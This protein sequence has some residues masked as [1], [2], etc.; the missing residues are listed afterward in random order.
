MKNLYFLLF[1]ISFSLQP[2]TAQNSTE[3]LLEN[4]KD[5]HSIPR[6][7]AYLHLN[8][9]VLLQGEQ[10]GFSAYIINKTDLKPSKETT[11]LYVQVKKEGGEIVREK[12]L[13]VEEGVASNL[14]EIDENFPTGSYTITAFTNWMRNFQEQ[15]FFTENFRVIETDLDHKAGEVVEEIIDVQFLPESGHLL[16]NVVNSIGII[17]KD[18]AGNGVA[19]A[20]VV[21]RD[22]ENRDLAN[23]RLNKFGIGKF[24]MIPDPEENYTAV[25]VKEE[26]EIPV[27][28]DTPIEQEGIILTTTQRGDELR[29]LVS[30]NAESL[31]KIERRPLTLTIQNR[32]LVDAHEIEFREQKTIPVIVDLSTLASGINI[33]TLFDENL[34]PI[35]ERL[36]FNHHDLPVM[37]M[38]TAQITSLQDSLQFK[39]PMPGTEKVNF[40][41]SILPKNTISANRHHNIIS[42]NLLQ[43]YVRG[44]IENAGWYFEENSQDRRFELDNLL[45][46]QG[47][48]SYDWDEIFNSELKFKHRF[49]KNFE[50]KAT[51]HSRDVD[52]RE[53][54]YLVHATANNN[55]L[56]AEIPSEKEAFIF[57]GFR[58]VEGEQIFI[59][60][61]KRN[62]KLVPA[63]LALQSFPQK[64]P[65]FHLEAD[66]LDQK[67]QKVTRS[68]NG[69]MQVF[70]FGENI[71]ELGEVL[72][73]TKLDKVK[74]R[75]R[76]LNNHI[77]GRAHV[78]E[79]DDIAM[80]GT[81]ANLLRSKGLRVSEAN[82]SFSVATAISGMSNSGAGG[83]TLEGEMGDI[84]GERE[85][86]DKTG[87]GSGVAVY[88]DGILLYDLTQLYQYPLAYVDYVEINNTGMGNGF[89]G[90]KGHIKI[91]T[92]RGSRYESRDRNR[93][94]EFDLPLAYSLE[95]EFYVPRY[96]STTDDFFQAYG[97]ID[98]KVG[99]ASENGEDVN[100]KIDKPKVDYQ[101]IIEGFT[102]AGNFVYDVQNFSVEQ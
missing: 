87:L 29:L 22:S 28:F 82:A 47:W 58:P 66:L 33:I 20:T 78:V 93:I 34:N 94:Q 89:I 2:V 64:F 55:P 52:K 50:L 39:L 40:S 23:V 32:N 14:I 46:T 102:D 84:I 72:L 67:L 10:L 38:P 12:L 54:R 21:V 57:D 13:L 53:L 61:I 9:V 41:V 74:E 95:K 60:R 59:S 101:M 25:V 68:S 73:E 92:I 35:A 6:E 62:D 1:A 37:D 5:Y 7:F 19:N 31:K 81:L 99:L 51:I 36:I 86:A 100:F 24:S 8:K 91:Y 80:Y 3:E 43:P 85:G 49:E 70:R 97:I 44:T 56:V 77:F 71:E 26:K 45:L 63:K 18:R 4:L 30:T 17:A 15:N 96:E 11:N 65:D 48:S 90:N 42:Y 88:M 75:E 27:T 98:W 16:T 83:F 69:L 76:R 79:D